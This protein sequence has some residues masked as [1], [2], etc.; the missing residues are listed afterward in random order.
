MDAGDQGHGS[1]RPPP[2]PEHP[3]H[4]VRRD[5]RRRPDAEGGEQHGDRR[6]RL[7]RTGRGPHAVAGRRA[8]RVRARGLADPAQGAA[9]PRKHVARTGLQHADRQGDPA[10]C[11]RAGLHPAARGP[12][13]HLPGRLLP[14]E[15]RT[16][17]LRR[18]RAAHAVQA[19]DPFAERRRRDVRLLRARDR[20]GRPA[21]LQPG[22][23][24]PAAAGARARLCAP[25]RRTHGAVPRRERRPH[26]RPPDAGMA[27]ALQFRRIRRNAPGR[28]LVH[29]EARQR[30]TGARGLEPVRPGP[31]NRTTG[32]VRAALPAADARHATPVR[33]APLDRRRP[34]RRPGHVAARDRRHR[35][36]G[37][38]R[39][40]EG[41]GNPAPV[42]DGNGT[43]AARPP[44]PARPAAAGGMERHRR[45]RRRAGRGFPAAW[46]PVDAA[47]LPL[48]RYRRHRRDDGRAAG[49][50]RAGRCGDRGVPRRRE[51]TRALPAAPDRVGCTRADG[52]QCARTGRRHR[53][54]A[55]HGRRTRHAVRADGD[56]AGGRR[57]PAHPRGR[58]AVGHLRPPQPDPRT[59]HPATPRARL[60]GSRRPV[61]R[62]VHAL[63]PGR[64]Q[65]I[66]DGHY[67]GA[68]R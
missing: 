38:G 54:H 52:R 8:H 25:A 11:H 60:R 40:R 64:E 24:P 12:R 2:A 53:G 50:A 47:R 29:G 68:C 66:G 5:H 63:Q 17:G 3:R 22:A 49:G 56:T 31:R 67:A 30:R 37:A 57:D 48:H 55:G 18:R 36:I 21:R 23:A 13:H 35:R 1:Q 61:R 34:V 65:R 42:R 15:R 51:G 33:P 62:A 26:P 32:R 16:Q 58:R 4:P 27:D 6:G 14:A 7:Q 10:G 41:A 43:G 45:V 28:H 59:R 9:V 19:H 20:P 39:V 44:C 46:A